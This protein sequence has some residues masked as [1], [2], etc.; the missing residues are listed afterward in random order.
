MSKL[1]GNILFT[2]SMGN[3]SAY[4][5]R[6][7]DKIILRTKGGASKD[8]IKNDPAFALTRKYN[9]EFGGCSKAAAFVRKAIIGLWHMADPDSTGQL[10]ALAHT[11]Q[12]LDTIH[13]AGERA[14]RFSQYRY[15]LDGFNM[16]SQLHFN[17]VIRHPVSVSVLRTNGS[18]RLELP[19][20]LPGVNF[21][22][23]PQYHI[24]R[25]PGSDLHQYRVPAGK[26]AY[27]SSGFL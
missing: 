22:T 17:T 2:G 8:K 12:K 4:K 21:Y 10:N 20:L 9:S 5:R 24:G 11:I 27:I 15:L 3:L 18:A 16:T 14:I 7:S 13:A 19:G 6:G 1:E 25:Y 26:P 23:A